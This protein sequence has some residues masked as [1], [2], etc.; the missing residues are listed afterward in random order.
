MVVLFVAT[1][2]VGLKHG[3]AYE[4]PEVIGSLNHE[5]QYRGTFSHDYCWVGDQNSDGYDD[6]MLSID[7]LVGPRHE[8][9]NLVNIY[10]GG[11]TIRDEPDIS[12]SSD[13]E[14]NGVGY[15]LNYVGNLLPDSFPFFAV[16]NAVYSAEE[17]GAYDTLKIELYE[18]G[19]EM[20]FISEFRIRTFDGNK[21][22][23]SKG[24]W[25][26]PFDFNGDGYHD[27]ITTEA[28]DE[29][30]SRLNIF[31]GGEDFDTIPDWSYTYEIDGYHS[32]IIKPHTGY[33]INGDGCDDLFIEAGVQGN[34]RFIDRLWFIYFGDEDP[35][36]IQ[37]LRIDPD[38]LIG[39]ISLNI[40]CLLPDINGDGYDEWGVSYSTDDP[41]DHSYGYY[42]FFGSEE[43]DLD[44]YLSFE[45]EHG[46]AAT[47][48]MIAGGDFNGDGFGDII[49]SSPDA[50]IGSG[51]F[52]IHF[53]SPW[54]S[55]ESSIIVRDAEE[56]YG[57]DF[58][59][60]GGSVGAI[61]D[62]NGDGVDDFVMTTNGTPPVFHLYIFAGNRDWEVGVKE[63]P[64]P[65]SYEL[66][67]EA[68]P[69]PFNSE[70]TI[71][72]V[73]SIQE[74]VRLSIYDTQGRLVERLLNRRMPNC[75]HTVRWSGE[76]KSGIYFALLE[77][78]EERTAYKLVNLK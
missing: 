6:L 25:R 13:A 39:D 28:I 72:F 32:T 76:G 65:K 7:P 48:N 29:N 59:S 71:S 2:L 3:N 56:A 19:E 58:G 42:I 61:G 8:Y 63:K 16:H 70:T 60:L 26:R 66:S 41:G 22:W 78:G 33:D 67:L 38:E 20:D 68:Y 54:Y 62:Y 64:I 18:G 10:F 53:G 1:L 23:I 40:P 49:T 30:Y 44:D 50:W 52:T 36:T 15:R 5:E 11:D 17:I 37:D 46:Y 21:Q 43:P 27:L 14:R 24:W 4:I 74:D 47:P 35:D 55:G 9:F 75:V 31:W 34:N 51:G 12:F 77:V 45:G 57:E 69:N 73:L